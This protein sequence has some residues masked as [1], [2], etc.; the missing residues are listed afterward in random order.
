MSYVLLVP[1]SVQFRVICWSLRR[2]ASYSSQALSI[3][4]GSC[5]NALIF[6]CGITH[7]VWIML[8]VKEI[9]SV[10]YDLFQIKNILQMQFEFYAK[11]MY[12][13]C[14]CFSKK[15]IHFPFGWWYYIQ[16][17]EKVYQDCCSLT[18]CICYFSH[19]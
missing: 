9:G 2:V 16:S 8:P 6:F 7:E 4:C 13:A 10:M 17:K 18:M 12:R 1:T 15:I 11:E 5:F 3:I 19:Y 14:R